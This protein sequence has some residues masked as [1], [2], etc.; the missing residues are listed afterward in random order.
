MVALFCVFPGTLE[1]LPRPEIMLPAL[2]L[3][4]TVAFALLPGLGGLLATL[5]LVF[6]GLAWPWAWLGLPLALAY[7]WRRGWQALGS[8]VG[9]A[10]GVALC[11]LGLA[12]LVQPAL[13]RADG[14]LEKADLP[15]GYTA[16]LADRETVV[17]D[18]QLP[19][20]EQGKS[21]AVSR[22]LWRSLVTSESIALK[23][24]DSTGTGLKIDWPNGVSG[25]GVL[26]HD[27]APVPAAMPVMQAAY[28]D[29]LTRAPT[30]T[31][32]AV[33]ARTVLESTWLHVGAPEP[34]PVGAWE[35]WSGSP[36]LSARMILIRRVVKAGV[37]VLVMWAALVIC[38]GRR[39]RPRHL[40][41]A[42]LLMASG[43]LLASESGAVTNL[44][45][46]MPL[47]TAL[48]AAHEPPPRH[49]ATVPTA[50]SYEPGPAPR[51]TLDASG[52]EV[53]H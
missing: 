43:A 36:T 5:C 17:I 42:M 27:V 13:P 6:A 41:G 40:L 26:Y 48:W 49:P 29:L 21:S 16:R 47:V 35:L 34:Q 24:A 51:I 9:L 53:P 32:V 15:P 50:I 11:W 19:T 12:A 23:Q 44:V 1:C 28:R 20:G 46:L 52:K 18:Q 22:W 31:R 33:A 30:P 3:T 39:N 10:G 45:W 2:L 14:A 37:L 4:W 7:F 25:E 8:T 38:L